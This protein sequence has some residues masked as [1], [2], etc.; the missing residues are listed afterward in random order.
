[1]KGHDAHTSPDGKELVIFNS[2][3]ILPC[4][5]VHYQNAKGE[6]VYKG[7]KT[8]EKKD[9]VEDDYEEENDDDEDD[10]DDNEDDEDVDLAGWSLPGVDSSKLQKAVDKAVA[11]P[12]SKILTGRNF[13]LYGKLMLSHGEVKDLLQKHG[14]TVGPLSASTEMLVVSET[15]FNEK[16]SKTIAKGTN[17]GVTIVPE[18][19]IFQCMSQGKLLKHSK[20]YV[21]SK[22][23]YKPW[24]CCNIGLCLW[25]DFFVWGWWRS[26]LCVRVFADF[27]SLFCDVCFWL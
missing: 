21:L 2:A 20:K 5:I 12:K 9:D 14:A 23:K 6:F 26:L 15:D 16:Y 24:W 11:K 10:E 18:N 25:I 17:L 13:S 22:G 7:L 19:Y 1:M 27:V 3:H 4:Y 8:G